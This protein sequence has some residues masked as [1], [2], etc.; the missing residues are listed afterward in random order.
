[1]AASPFSYGREKFHEWQRHADQLALPLRL[2][3]PTD[4]RIG[5]RKDDRH[6]NDKNIREMS[7]KWLSNAEIQ[8]RTGISQPTTRKHIA[9]D[10]FSSQV[11]RAQGHPLVLDLHKPFVDSILMEDRR[12]HAHRL[13]QRHRRGPQGGAPG[14]PRRSCSGGWGR[15]TGSRRPLHASRECGVR[16]HSDASFARDLLTEHKASRGPCPAALRPSRGGSRACPSLREI[17]GWGRFAS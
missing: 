7:R 13:R 16:L 9:M 15:T 14:S 3:L 11:P 5:G 2:Q 12:A 8:R 1:M 4:D 6:A 17:R 10:D